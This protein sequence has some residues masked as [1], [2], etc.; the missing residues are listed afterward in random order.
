MRAAY[1]TFGD[2][3]RTHALKVVLEATPVAP[4]L[5]EREETAVG[6]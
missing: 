4:E 1:D 5:P 3:A 6:V 2:A